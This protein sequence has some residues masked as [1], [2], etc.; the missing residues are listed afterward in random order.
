VTKLPPL[1]YPFIL[2]STPKW[3]WYL[4]L[5]ECILKREKRTNQIPHGTLPRIRHKKRKH[6]SQNS[7]C[8][9][10]KVHVRRQHTS[11]Q[12][13]TAQNESQLWKASEETQR[14]LIIDYTPSRCHMDTKIHMASTAS[15]SPQTRNS[16]H[17][18]AF[19]ALKRIERGKQNTFWYSD[20]TQDCAV[21]HYYDIWSITSEK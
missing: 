11:R 10:I 16:P 6:S 13:P 19:V 4:K 17:K 7:K 5:T 12:Q 2:R 21:P 20:A 9:E 8:R 15:L 14:S 1:I 3:Y 18:L